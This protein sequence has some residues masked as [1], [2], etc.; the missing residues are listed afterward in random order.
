[1]YGNLGILR[2]FGAAGDQTGYSFENFCSN[3]YFQFFRGVCA[4]VFLVRCHFICYNVNLKF[5]FLS[6]D[7]LDIFV[8]KLF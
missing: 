1:M 7:K 2:R 8:C 3:E 5:N 4:V 6:N